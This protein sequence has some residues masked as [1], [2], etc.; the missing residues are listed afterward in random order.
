MIKFHV[1]AVNLLMYGCPKA[2]PFK[3]DKEN[4]DYENITWDYVMDN[5][6]SK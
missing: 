6:V 1:D 2:I 3:Y 4:A 5:V